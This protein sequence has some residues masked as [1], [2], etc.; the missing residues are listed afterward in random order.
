[1]STPKEFKTWWG[2]LGPMS[3]FEVSAMPHPTHQTRCSHYLTTFKWYAHSR[4]ANP[5]GVAF[6]CWRGPLSK[7]LE[8]YFEQSEQ[9]QASIHL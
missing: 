4:A 5:T 1:M 6:L 3:Q 9:I 8:A 2:T 7:K